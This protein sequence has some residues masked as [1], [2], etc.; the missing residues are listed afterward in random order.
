MLN[1]LVFSLNAVAPLAVLMALGVFLRYRKILSEAFFLSANK[2]SF[3]ILLPVM[4]FCNIYDCRESATEFDWRYVGIAMGCIVGAFI[5][6]MLIVPLVARDKTRIGVIIQGIFR[7]N[8]LVFGVPVVTNM[9]G[10]SELWT[11]SMLLPFII[12]TFNMLAVFAL[13]WYITPEHGI[14]RLRCALIEILK[15]PL[16]IASILSYAVILTRITLPSALYKTLS[17]LKDVGTPLA[18]IALGGTLTFSSMRSN[19]KALFGACIG[20]L[21]LMPALVLPIALT[22]GYRGSTI[23]ALLAMAGSP[24]AISSYVM[25]QQCG[26]DGDLAGQVVVITTIGSV[27]TMFVWIFALRAC[28]VL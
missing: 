7:S 10:E 9:F 22:F 18:L 8:F 16:I 1:T 23:G 13:T 25:A 6:L 20:K 15:N 24:T 26:N 21:V 3:S 14:K 2:L 5:L 19:A 12:P 27:V 11:T 17:N 4:L 28:G